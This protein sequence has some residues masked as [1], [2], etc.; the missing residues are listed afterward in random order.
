MIARNVPDL[1]T[2]LVI[3]CPVLV[4]ER[5]VLRP[6]H[7]EDLPE[8]IVYANNAEVAKMLSRMPHPYGET[9]ARAF[10]QAAKAERRAGITYAVTLADTGAFIGTASLIPSKSGGLELGYW[11]GQL[12]WGFGFASEAAQALTELAFRTT[13]LDVLEATARTIN[14]A[15]RRVLEKCGFVYRGEGEVYSTMAGRVAVDK[16]Q[17]TREHWLDFVAT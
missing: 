5:L 10:I 11:I 16:F 2:S 17:L 3:D 6:P 1:E 15:S 14:P 7:D 4:T 9:E 12:Y 13:T 8:L